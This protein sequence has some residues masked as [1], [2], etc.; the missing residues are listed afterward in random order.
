MPETQPEQETVFLVHA[1]S[2]GE[3]ANAD[4]FVKLTFELVEEDGQWCGYC[5]ELGTAAFSDTR[6]QA[7]AELSEA[8]ELQLVEVEKLGE[9]QEYLAQNEVAIFPIN[10]PA[11]GERGFTETVPAQR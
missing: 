3:R 11:Q 2:D 5:T 4:Y 10:I 1:A 7:R 9:I 8:T 6:E